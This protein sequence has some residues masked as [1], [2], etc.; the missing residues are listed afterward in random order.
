MNIQTLASIIFVLILVVIGSYFYY[1][2]TG[3][4]DRMAAYQNTAYGVSFEY[5]KSYK[6]TEI[7]Q[8]GTGTMVT[9]F[10]KEVHVPQ[11]G[12]GPTAITV[13]MYDN[14]PAAK[15]GK[16]PAQ[17][18]IDTSPY[19]NSKLSTMTPGTTQIGGQDGLLYTWDGLY[20]GTTVVTEHNGAVIA[21]TVTYDGD[22]DMEK[23]EAFTK[24]IESVRFDG[25]S[26]TTTGQ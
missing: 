1:I 9:I 5:P 12:E 3:G 6:L 8:N 13:N 21:F 4:K 25:N 23:R 11:D 24:L 20:Q 22:T 14:A 2:K 7:V 15:G 10:E 17:I 16:S 26:A 19:S 18:W